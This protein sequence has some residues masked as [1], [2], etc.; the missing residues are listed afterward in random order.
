MIE[1]ARLRT[2]VVRFLERPWVSGHEQEACE[3][4]MRLDR[5]RRERV[6][7]SAL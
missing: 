5:Q 4:A 2:Y 3:G 6:T 1:A 7:S